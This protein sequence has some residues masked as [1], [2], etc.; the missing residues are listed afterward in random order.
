MKCL[1]LQETHKNSNR[2]VLASV[3]VAFFVMGFGLANVI[4]NSG[5][6]DHHDPVVHANV[7]FHL[8]EPVG[9][10]DFQS[11]N[12]MTTL[13]EENMRN[14]MGFGN[15]TSSTNYTQYI[16]LGNATIANTLT[17]LGVEAT[18]GNFS[19]SLAITNV[20]WQ[21]G[22]HYAFNSTYT[23]YCTATVA[24]NATGFHWSGVSDSS[25]NMA[26]CAYLTDGTMHQF[27]VTSNCTVTW[28]ITFV[29]S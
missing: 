21:N 12:V 19:R 9:V 25:G 27:T 26:A 23:W 7:F 10:S 17:K 4:D 1:N 15:Q 22:T 14:W 24:V 3:M 18:T 20:A 13:S 29:A 28:V 16:S 6:L 2:I 11:G 8:E 5:F